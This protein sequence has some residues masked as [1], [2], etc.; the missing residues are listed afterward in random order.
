MGRSSISCAP[1]LCYQPPD[2]SK[3]MLDFICQIYNEKGEGIRI[4][5]PPS[6]PA[7]MD[8]LNLLCG[9]EPVEW[10]DKSS[11]NK[12]FVCSQTLKDRIHEICDK[13]RS[14]EYDLS[15]VEE[16]F[17]KQENN[18]RLAFLREGILL[19][20][21]ENLIHKAIPMVQLANFRAAYDVLS[22]GDKEYFTGPYDLRKC[23]CRFCNK[24]YPE[25]RF[26]K[27]NAHA[28]PDALGNKLVFCNDECVKCNDD[29]SPV[30]K[31]LTEYLKLRRSLNKIVN[32]KN[33]VIQVW[34]HNF[35]YNGPTK[36]LQIS[37][38][39]ILKKTDNQ[40]HVKL[41][42]ADP[43]SH[44]GI[45]KSLA[46]IAIDLMPRELVNEYQST[47]NWIKGKF[48][49]PVLPD[50]F[51]AYHNSS[52]SQ[53]QAKVFVRNEN[54]PDSKLPKCMVALRL[55]DLTYFYIIPLGKEEE[56][57]KDD[58]L[59]NYLGCI[60]QI[61]QPTENGVF[62]EKIDMADRT[63]KFAHVEEW[64]DC[65]ECEIVPQSQFDHTQEKSPNKVDFPRFDPT[66]VRII[67][68][69]IS[70][71]HITQN[72]RLHDVKAEDCTVKINRQNLDFDY[73]PALYKCDWEIEI[74]S[75]QSQETI[76]TA[77]CKI[78][79]THKRISKVCSKN[80]GEISSFLIEYL[81]DAVCRRIGEEVAGKFGQ[82]DFSQLA[83]RL[84]ESEGLIT[85]PKENVEQSVMKSYNK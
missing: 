65:T 77:A 4:C 8:M 9:A 80:T 23:I 7:W 74:Q 81:L 50:V 27:K 43:I 32:K 31:E 29:L 49:P 16:Y 68:T 72:K 42:G 55:M 51:Y 59:K 17:K 20:I 58:Y 71:G 18:T 84:M 26:K 13:H 1:F 12:L 60:L 66:L 52:I 82:Y 34:G 44:L 36:E 5:L 41:E 22:F 15:T 19:R 61:L 64:I 69:K 75:L 11:L 62:M 35:F 2:P 25:A 48:V 63:G 54:L 6:H 14:T 73:A 57:Y 30:D 37:E 67:D 83:E 39:A 53:P 38:L 28:I 47:I 33:K 3:S 46:K 24:K 10:V 85:H 45:Y 76:L 78:R 79:F 56:I 21:D 40:F 70:I